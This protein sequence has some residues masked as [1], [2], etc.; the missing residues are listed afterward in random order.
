FPTIAFE[1]VRFAVPSHQLASL[2]FSGD[3]VTADEAVTRGLVDA[4]VDADGLM[5]A[6]LSEASRLAALTAAE[7]AITKHQ[8]R[9]PSF[10]LI[11]E[12]RDLVYAEIRK[13]CESPGA[14]DAIR[15]YVARTFKKS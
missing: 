3:T 11:L 14:L 6:A 10:D 7:F 9:E 12:G 2:V 5:D 1:I 15:A 13:Y 4:S 8:L